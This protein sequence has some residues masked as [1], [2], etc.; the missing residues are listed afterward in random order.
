[1]NREILLNGAVFLTDGTRLPIIA[2]IGL[3]VAISTSGLS[4]ISFW[5]DRYRIP[6]SAV[7][8]VISLVVFQSPFSRDYVFF[9]DKDVEVYL[10]GMLAGYEDLEEGDTVGVRYGQVIDE[11]AD[12]D[13]VHY[14]PVHYHPPRVSTTARGYIFVKP[15]QIRVSRIP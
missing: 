13:G 2:Y 11:V 1:M 6:T 9:V 3:I 7:C 4:G 8:V 10:N 15:E 5:L 12:G 14:D